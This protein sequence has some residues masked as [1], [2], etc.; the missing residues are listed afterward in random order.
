MSVTRAQLRRSIGVRT[1]QPFFERYNSGYLT[2]SSVGPTS[3]VDQGNLKQ[4]DDFW[5]GQY[6]YLPGYD[7]S[8]VISGFVSSTGTL[9]FREPISGNITDKRYEIWGQ[10]S[11][12]D[13]NA[14]INQAILDSW[15]FFFDSVRE[16]IVIKYGTNSRLSLSKTARFIYRVAVENVALEHG[17]VTST[18][19]RQDYLVDSSKSFDSS[20]IGKE[21]RIHKG[22]SAGDRR[23]ITEVIN[24]STV[25]VASA[26][27]SRLDTTS[28]YA[29]APNAAEDSDYDI[30]FVWDVQ[31][32]S[33][34]NAVEFL[35]SLEYHYGLIA[36]V[37]YEAEFQP[38]SSDTD[39]TDC[40]SEYIELAAIARLYLIRL[41]SAPRSE[42]DTWIGLQ[43]A[44]SEAARAYAQTYAYRHNAGVIAMWGTSRLLPEPFREG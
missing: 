34:S 44:Y 37:D 12:H 35:T 1:R 10:F 40:P 26:F 28:E 7:I 42:M 18:P 33:N 39:T 3:L 13:V 38:L 36:R 15:P 11:A 31:G 8:R 22:T 4:E 9:R 27:T 2:A 43:R 41:A 30:V 14:A 20:Y 16:Y 32:A 25:K 19:S 17:T 6:L 24:S 29:I 5:N 21:V 23:V